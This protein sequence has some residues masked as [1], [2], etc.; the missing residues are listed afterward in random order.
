MKVNPSLACARSG[1]AV[2]TMVGALLFLTSGLESAA[3]LT[4]EE[5]VELIY[6]LEGASDSQVERA[7]DVIRK[8]FQ[9][10]GPVKKGQVTVS[11]LRSQEISV[12]LP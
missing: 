10:F 6:R 5:G 3:A 2:V 12:K 9:Q 8:R 7:I 4:S 1:I 11:L